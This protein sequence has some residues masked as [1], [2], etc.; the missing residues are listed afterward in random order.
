[1]Q[2]MK[3][4]IMKFLQ[5]PVIYFLLGQKLFSAPLSETLSV[6]ACSLPSLLIHIQINMQYYSFV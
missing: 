2:I 3:L 6:W 1:M 4:L 5:S